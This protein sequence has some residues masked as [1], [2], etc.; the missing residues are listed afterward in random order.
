[1]ERV[2]NRAI[3][4]QQSHEA[5]GKILVMI[6]H[7]GK[8]KPELQNRCGGI[9]G[10]LGQQLYAVEALQAGAAQT[11]SLGCYIAVRENVAG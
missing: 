3:L 6:D 9:T 4:P 5:L 2:A 8:P 11:I 1:M 10:I 7:D